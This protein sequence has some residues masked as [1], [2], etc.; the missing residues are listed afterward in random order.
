[1]DNSVFSQNKDFLT[2]LISENQEIGIVI[3]EPLN[4]DKVAAGLALYLIF[5]QIGKDV[6]IISSREP[7]VEFSNLVGIDKIR[8]E[9]SG[10]TRYMTISLPY[11]EGE[12]EK[13]S[14]KIEG[15]RLN[16]NLFAGENKMTFSENDIE[17]IKK[18]A[19]PSLIFTVSVQNAEKLSGFVSLNSDV[20][21]VNIDNS[22]QN[23][24]YGDIV[25][26]SKSFSS[27]TEIVGKIV[28]DLALPLDIDSAQN[29]LDGILSSTNNFTSSSTSPYAFEVTSLLLKHGAKRAQQEHDSFKKRV[30]E[31][32]PI[33][34]SQNEQNEP[35]DDLDN[36]EDKTKENN[37]S[38][39]PQDW[40]SPKIFRGTKKQE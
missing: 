1:M 21:V 22:D 29:L 36:Y 30:S 5:R 35:Q 19:N 23:D 2:N 12:I 17:Y 31:S 37:I 34:V 39:V 25:Y 27:I 40:F 28:S 13:V 38:D 7:I 15:N 11:N 33:S 14:Y 3:G 18:G 24:A 4:L 9:F 8:K 10:M 6:Q 16:I 32:K 20:K 26:V